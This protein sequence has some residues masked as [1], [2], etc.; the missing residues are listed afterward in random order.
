LTPITWIP[1]PRCDGEGKIPL[2]QGVDAVCGQ[3]SGS[4]QI[5]KVE[6]RFK[7]G[8]NVKLTDA[9]RH[10]YGFGPSQGQGGTG[11]VVALRDQSSPDP[12][13]PYMVKWPTHPDPNSYRDEDLTTAE[14]PKKGF[15]F[16]LVK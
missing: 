14:P 8:D 10:K 1:C 4:G 11:E 3:C 2:P 15:Q 13:R 5:R 12:T 9:A 16:T 7:I 6:L